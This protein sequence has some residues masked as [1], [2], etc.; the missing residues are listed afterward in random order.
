MTVGRVPRLRGCQYRVI[1]TTALVCGLLAGLM[2]EAPQAWAQWTTDG[3]N[4][5]FNG[6]NIG[7]GT[8]NPG[9]LVDIMT[10]GAGTGLRLIGTVS[11]PNNAA[12]AALRQSNSGG[13]GLFLR[14]PT[15]ST[16]QILIQSGGDSFLAGG[17]VGIG[18]TTPGA[19]LHL[20][21]NA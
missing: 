11:A 17:N 3:A 1:A 12:I 21:Q 9:D 13:G 2:T 4:I 14:D 18:T 19:L 6:G 15:G 5:Y 8:T 7:I 10:T 16:T 20:R